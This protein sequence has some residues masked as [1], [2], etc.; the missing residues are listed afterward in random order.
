MTAALHMLG[1]GRHSRV[2]FIAED[3]RFL[4][5]TFFVVAVATFLVQSSVGLALVLAYITVLLLVAGVGGRRLAAYARTLV[6][7]ILAIVAINGYFVPGRPLPAPLSVLSIEG[8]VAGLYY[9]LRVLV[10]LTAT[11]LFLSV[12]PPESI[13]AGVASILR[14]VSSALAQRVALHAFVAMGFVPLFAD[15]ID[16]IRAAQSFRGG[17]SGRGLLR[18]IGG[19]RLLIVP[20]VVSAVHRSAQL[21]MA[22]EVRGIAE[23]IVRVLV[24]RA[25]APRDFA[26]VGVT[27]LVLVGAVLL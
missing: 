18:G 11:V 16:R 25:P 17:W 12:T 13:A 20:L 4:I 24:L 26:F 27:V 8:L 1:R 15:E 23:S 2:P 10:L 21:A 5:L 14:P 7:F 9:S 19:V 6:F 22:V 3:P